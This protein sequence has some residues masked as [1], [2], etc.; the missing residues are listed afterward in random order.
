MAS[1]SPYTVK[2]YG[3]L[4]KE[5]KDIR[6]FAKHFVYVQVVS[7]AHELQNTKILHFLKISVSN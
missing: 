1:D 2:V 5:V 3:A 4:F 6:S 7:N